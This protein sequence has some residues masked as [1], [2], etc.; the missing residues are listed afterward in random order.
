MAESTR[1]N[2]CLKDLH[3]L[4]SALDT[5]LQTLMKPLTG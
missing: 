2:R 1:L 4:A 5:D 3:K